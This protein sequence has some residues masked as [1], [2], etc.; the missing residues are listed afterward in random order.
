MGTRVTGKVRE[1]GQGEKDAPNANQKKM[2]PAFLVLHH[3][4]RPF[5]K[6]SPRLS[7]CGS[8]SLFLHPGCVHDEMVVTNLV[9][10]VRSRECERY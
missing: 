10:D 2:D 4:G 6:S 7:E 9:W 8:L 5:L 1:G 3:P